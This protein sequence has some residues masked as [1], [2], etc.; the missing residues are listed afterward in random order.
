MSVTDSHAKKRAKKL[1]AAEK[2]EAQ[3]EANRKARRQWYLLAAALVIITIAA[4]VL[5][6]MFT[7]GEIPSVGAPHA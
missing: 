6:T 7:E 5:V 2:R 3:L 4:I 1:T